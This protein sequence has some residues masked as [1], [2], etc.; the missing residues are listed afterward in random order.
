MAVV[1]YYRADGTGPYYKD[2]TNVPPGAQIVSTDESGD[3]GY[4]GSA[5]ID[6]T[7]N[8]ISVADAVLDDISDNSDAIGIN[9][10]AIGDNAD[11]ISDNADDIGTNV[12]AISLNTDKRT[13]PLVDENKL[14]TIDED[15]EEN[16]VQV[17]GGEI[18]AGTETALRSFSPA[19]VK[20][21]IDA[22]S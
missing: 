11:D 22:H 1:K 21:M 2:T 7:L 13:Y 20:A 17:T 15:A 5:S 4:S 9:I 19:D 12:T 8:V 14:A 10:T 3:S 6:I 16:P 18:A